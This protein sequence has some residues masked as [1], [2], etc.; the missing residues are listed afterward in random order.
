MRLRLRGYELRYRPVTG[1]LISEADAGKP[2]SLDSRTIDRLLRLALAEFP[3][4]VRALL[5]RDTGHGR[6][7]DERTVL[8]E[9][10]HMIERGQL[11]FVALPQRTTS[12][13]PI[14]D[15]LELLEPTAPEDIVEHEDWIEI[16]I[17]DEDDQPV[18]DVA[19]ELELPDGSIR[20]GRTDGEGIARYEGIPSGD[21][22]LTLIELD[23]NA[24]SYPA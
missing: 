6:A 9:L 2:V 8:A 10:R 3:H 12:A 16:L 11:L 23:T 22:K 19:F 5:N 15:E 17:A 1:E 13:R 18:R 21:C 14:A 7:P 4:R 20:R 24:W